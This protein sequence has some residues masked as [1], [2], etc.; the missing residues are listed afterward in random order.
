MRLLR[1]TNYLLEHRLLSIIGVIAITFIPMVGVIGILFAGLVT[2]RKGILEGALFTTAATLPYL[3]NF[4]FSNYPVAELSFLI[5]AAVGIAILSNTLT[6][7]FA[8][9]LYKHVHWSQL[10]QIAALLGVLLVSIIHLANPSVTNWWGNQLSNYY[11]K[12]IIITKNIQN[13]SDKTPTES[14]LETINL[15][16]QYATGLM[17]MAI[18]FN[19]ILQLI[20]SRW[21]QTTLFYPGLLRKELHHIRLSRLASILFV[22]SMILAY[23]DNKVAVDIMPILYML[24]GTA[25][26]SLIHCLLHTMTSTTKWFW[27]WLIYIIL[28]IALPT[29]LMLLSI[30]ALFDSEWNIRFKLKKG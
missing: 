7:I 29:S 25:G 26:L 11:E 17:T 1:L 20:A 9:M 5:W 12:A 2:L 8:S 4:Y 28:V 27:L 30:V 14:Q 19:A 13:E 15:T 21:W 16:K 18:L 23:L 3:I 22:L 10:L 6:W 24:F